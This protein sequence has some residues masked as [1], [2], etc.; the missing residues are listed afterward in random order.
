MKAIWSWL[1]GL[2]GKK[3]EEQSLTSFKMSLASDKLV[4]FDVNVVDE[5]DIELILDAII[6]LSSGEMSNGILELLM[7]H[8]VFGDLLTEKIL[9]LELNIAD[10]D[11]SG[12]AILPS[13]TVL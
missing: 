11:D 5:K 2:L 10:N 3:Q 9:N 7:K 12:P 6:S 13:Q 4:L 8:P 1:K